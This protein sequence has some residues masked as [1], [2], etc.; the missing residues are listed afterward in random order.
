MTLDTSIGHATRRPESSVTSVAAAFKIRMSEH[1]ANAFS[2]RFGI[3]RARA[4][5]RIAAQQGSSNNKG[6]RGKRR[7]DSCSCQATEGPLFSHDK[8]FVS[9]QRN[10]VL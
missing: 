4:E 2:A 5:D 1:T 9:C 10:S 3:E 7:S 6:G 8:S